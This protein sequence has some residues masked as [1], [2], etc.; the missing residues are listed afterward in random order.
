MKVIDALELVLL[1]AKIP[2]EEIETY[3]YAVTELA[4]NNPSYPL[5]SVKSIRIETSA[6]PV[7]GITSNNLYSRVISDS[8]NTNENLGQGYVYKVSD[9][10]GYRYLVV[11]EKLTASLAVRVFYKTAAWNR[12][13]ANNKV[14]VED[15]FTYEGFSMLRYTAAGSAV[16]RYAVFA[17][18]EMSIKGIRKGIIQK[19]KEKELN[20]FDMIDADATAFFSDKA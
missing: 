9:E 5:D 18:S 12:F 4:N 20:D 19:L 13:K 17:D 14:S 3:K 7:S 15:E 6:A 10:K 11:S 2:Q 8:K 1:Y 16:P